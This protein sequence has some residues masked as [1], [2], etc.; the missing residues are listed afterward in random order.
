MIYI[1]RRNTGR[2]ERWFPTREHANLYVLDIGGGG[3]FSQG[4][5]GHGS[6]STDIVCFQFPYFKS[7]TLVFHHKIMSWSLDKD[8]E[9]NIFLLLN[10]RRAVSATTGEEMGKIT[11]ADYDQNAT[12]IWVN[13][14]YVL[15]LFMF[16]LIE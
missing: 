4:I 15:S 5:A 7:K 3:T 13:V 1:I 12:S 10:G 16:F 9:N 8:E 6:F 14:Q 11:S 2:Q